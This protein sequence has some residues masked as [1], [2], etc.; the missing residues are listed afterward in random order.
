MKLE[1]KSEISNISSTNPHRIT[2]TTPTQVSYILFGAKL[3]SCYIL[4]SNLSEQFSV[5]VTA[6]HLQAARNILL[7]YNWTADCSLISPFL[8][9]LH[10]SCN[11]LFRYQGKQDDW[12]GKVC[13]RH[14]NRLHSINS[15]TSKFRDELAIYVE[16]WHTV[17]QIWI[18]H[19]S[20]YTHTKRK[21]KGIYL[22][23]EL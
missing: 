20:F 3:L 8:L 6:K 14:C 4:W 18:L 5:T 1:G 7:I 11:L 21:G 19:L 10:S 12:R 17:R 15:A 13:F 23:D 16:A 9:E 2:E 22:R